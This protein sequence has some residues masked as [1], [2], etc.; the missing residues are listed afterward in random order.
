MDLKRVGDGDSCAQGRGGGPNG[1]I[2]DILSWV[3][4]LTLCRSSLWRSIMQSSC[5]DGR[6]VVAFA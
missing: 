2:A 5:G 1:G 3:A 4:D 6:R